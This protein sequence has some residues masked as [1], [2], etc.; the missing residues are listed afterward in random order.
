MKNLKT[1]LKISIC[2]CISFAASS[3]C[4]QKIFKE[5]NGFLK[6]EAEAFYKQTNDSIRKWYIID[7]SFETALKDADTSHAKIASNKKYIEILPDTRQTHD[8]QLI[9]EENFTSS[10]GSMAVV[11]YKIHIKNPG[12]YY[13]WVKAY[14]TGSEDNGLHVGLDGKWPNSGKR[15]QWCK[16]KKSWFWESKQRTKEEHCGKPNAIYLDIKTAGRHEIQFSMREDGFEM[17][18]WLITSDQNY[19]PNAESFRTTSK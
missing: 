14:S 8:D 1:F 16:G 13:I 4:S 3:V 19:N 7:K 17:D 10:P 11:C 2:F 15:M 5:N 6:V 18:E 12:R 9:R